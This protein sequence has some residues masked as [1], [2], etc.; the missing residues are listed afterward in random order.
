MARRPVTPPEQGE[1]PTSAGVVTP[2][3]PLESPAVAGG[4]FAVPG[5]DATR[6]DAL[7]CA[8]VKV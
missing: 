5:G 6:Q 7:N 3:H 1:G 4:A 2:H 8:Y